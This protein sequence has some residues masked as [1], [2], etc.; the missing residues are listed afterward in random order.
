MAVYESVS[1]EVF[2]N[3][4]DLHDS[5][6]A[7][8]SLGMGLYHTGVQIRDHEYSFSDIGVSRTRARLPEFGSFREQIVMG[9]F[10]RGIGEI[11]NIITAMASGPFAPT[12]YNLTSFNCNHFSDALCFALL[13]KN[14]PPWIN[15]MAGIGSAILPAGTLESVTGG[16]Q[17]S[18][19]PTTSK[20]ANAPGNSGSFAALGAVRSPTDP[21]QQPRK[22]AT[23][24]E[25]VGDGN[26]SNWAA[27]IFSWFSGSSSSSGCN[28]DSSSTSVPA[29]NG[30]LPAVPGRN[31]TTNSD[32]NKSATAAVVGPKKELTDKQKELLQ[33]VKKGGSA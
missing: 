33:K 32:S 8:H 5:N 11:N 18:T 21:L 24:S 23:S 31:A 3:V 22:E 30:T 14:I 20:T 28:S 26:S 19:A 17:Q 25:S 12:T 4:Y 13:E 2:L 6:S 7:L 1:C 9:V 10:H 29:K 15:R 16:N 27:S